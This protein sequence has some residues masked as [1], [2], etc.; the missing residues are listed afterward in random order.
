MILQTPDS[1]VGQIP[2]PRLGFCYCCYSLW[3]HAFSGW[4]HLWTQD[5]HFVFPDPGPYLGSAKAPQ[6]SILDRL[7]RLGT[8]CGPDT[9]K[10]LPLSSCRICKP[11]SYSQFFVSQWSNA[12]FS[13]FDFPHT[14][15]VY[16]ALLSTIGLK[17]AQDGRE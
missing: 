9:S 13:P 16:L 14:K 3:S 17:E 4:T 12:Y 1:W 11:H 8:L 15:K 7:P 2:G 10:A 5:C 6:E